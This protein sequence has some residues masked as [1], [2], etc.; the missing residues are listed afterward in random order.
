MV[1][2]DVGMV[3]AQAGIFDFERHG[4]RVAVRCADGTTLTYAAL[5]RAADAAATGFGTQRALVL[6][7]AANALPPLLAYLGAMRAGHVVLLASG[8]LPADRIDALIATYGANAGYRCVGEDWRAWTSGHAAPALHPD[9]SLLLSTSGSTGSAKLVRLSADAVQANAASIA[10]YLDITA[11]DRALTTLP[12]HYSYGLS[13]VHSHLLCGATL[14]LTDGSVVDPELWQ[15]AADAKVTSI[16]GVPYTYELLERIRFRDHPPASLRT[17]TQA[18][19]R[20][21]G[22][23]ARD[24]AE[25]AAAHHARF[26]V[27]Y[28][29]TEATARMAYMPPHQLAD[30]PDHI[31]VAIP[32]GAFAL[33]DEA[34]AE[35][36]EAD[37]PG[38]LVYRGPNVMMGYGLTAADLARPAELDA[39]RTGD[40]AQR[41]GTGLYRI[42]GR[43]S[44]FIKPFGVRIGLDDVEAILRAQ[45][46]TAAA[47]G[48]D[49]LLAIQVVDRGGLDAGAVRDRLADELRLPVAAIDLAVVPELS[50]LASGKID[51]QAILGAARARGAAGPAAA[52]GGEGVAQLFAQAFPRGAIDRG[53]SFAT[54]GGDSLNYVALSMGLER[55]LGRL[56]AQWEQLTVAELEALAPTDPPARRAW[57]SI[58]WFESEVLIRML[59]IL[60]VVMDHTTN[61]WVVGGGAYM[62]LMLFGYNL[63]RYQFA[64]LVEGRGIRILRN[65][66]LRIILPYYLLV[67]L[68]TAAKRTVDWPTLLLVGNYVGRFQSLLEPYWFLEMLLQMIVFVVVLFAFRPV[69]TWTARNPWD[70]GL[71]ALI[72]GLV[73]SMVFNHFVPRPV[74]AY[75]TPEL[76]FWLVALGWCMHRA[77][78]W[79]RHALLAAVVV[80]VTLIGNY[81]PAGAELGF[82]DGPVSRRWFV[83]ACLLMLFVPRLPLPAAVGPVIALVA[84]SSFYIYLTHIIP[85]H[86]ALH[87][88]HIQ[89]DLLV[90]AIALVPGLVLG[91]VVSVIQARRAGGVSAAAEA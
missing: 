34:G 14:L 58:R 43:L 89:T 59:A 45:V 61:R 63:S 53:A 24:Y 50:L 16:A 31:G 44:R 10:T 32:G 13:V 22:A 5:A 42:V 68:W 37:R 48:D 33:I 41:N 12:F 71:V 77:T 19:G 40:I 72:A 49:A 36:T 25:W 70:A 64:W 29:Q 84:G 26:F 83:G 60:A 17:L 21:P 11:E 23:L 79:R 2:G 81:H 62:L 73:A 8:E 27:M 38:E 57:W 66:A 15:F 65:F 4:D 75:R 3:G 30:F 82:A 88:L 9:L 91:W 85:I 78:G 67:L 6:I 20:L 39:L 69:R 55:L 74:L 7:E 35:I 56:P 87:V 18:G 1:T 46:L 54:L 76:L 52:A 80:M 90:F 47:T 28:G 86:V 51:Y